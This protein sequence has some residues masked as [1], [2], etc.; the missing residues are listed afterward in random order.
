MTVV[1][2]LLAFSL[3]GFTRCGSSW[4]L[5]WSEEFDGLAGQAPNPALWTAEIGTGPGE[6]GWGNKQLEYDTDRPENVALDG[7]GHLVITALKESYQGSAYTSARLKTQG[8]REQKQ[9]RIEARIKMPVGKGLWPAFWLLGTDIDQVGWPTCGE[10]DVVEY[11]GQQPLAVQGS[12]HGPGY[13]GGNPLTG[14][15]SLPGPDGFDQDFHVF[16]IE[17]DEEQIAFEVDGVAYQS[18]QHT[19]PYSDLPPGTAWVFD[20]PFFI[21]LN[22]AVGGTFV[23]TPN[24]AT[25]FPQ[26]MV[27]DYIRVYERDP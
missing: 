20:K 16:G 18:F 10:I 21:L 1:L 26:A 7:E 13:S 9:G 14:S 3:T 5:A 4:K 19:G 17:W 12:L 25:T 2:S 23:G 27:I 15:F 22:L 8:K 6:D 11:R 24:A